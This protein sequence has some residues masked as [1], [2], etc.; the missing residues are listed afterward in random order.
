MAKKKKSKNNQLGKAALIIGLIL[1]IVAGLIPSIEAYAYTGLI[2]VV[3]GL[4]VGLM[5][6]AEKDTSKL[7]IAIIALMAVGTATI[8]VIPLIN[9]YLSAMLRNFLAFVGAAGFVV[10]IKAILETSRI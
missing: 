9:E 1:A 4:V 3:L 5:N 7:L 2:L 10:A 8:N 6:I